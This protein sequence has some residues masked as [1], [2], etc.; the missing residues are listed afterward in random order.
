MVQED[1]GQIAVLSTTTFWTFVREFSSLEAC[2]GQDQEGA[3]GGFRKPGDSFGF[4][5]RFRRGN[6]ADFVCS[7]ATAATTSGS[8]DSGGARFEQLAGR[9][10]CCTIC[11]HPGLAS[12]LLGGFEF[13]GYS[14]AGTEVHLVGRLTTKRGVG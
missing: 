12:R 3:V 13:N 4:A 2:A 1:R 14:V 5:H 11:L 6:R 9:A 8:G 10:R 7:L